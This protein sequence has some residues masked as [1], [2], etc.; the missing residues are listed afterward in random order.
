M[1]HV[2][3]QVENGDDGAWGYSTELG[4]LE[5][6]EQLG[7]S[8]ESENVQIGLGWHGVEA[9]CEIPANGLVGPFDILTRTSARVRQTNCRVQGNFIES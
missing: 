8:L 3:V 1:R 6:G 2:D 9:A 7:I 5:P 4:V